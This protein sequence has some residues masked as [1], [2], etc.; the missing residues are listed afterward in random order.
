MC[1]ERHT[2]RKKKFTD[3]RKIV[4]RSPN[5]NSGSFLGAGIT[6][7]FYFIFFCTFFLVFSTFSAVNTYY[8]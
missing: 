4:K 3:T 7:D 6:G 8:F 2:Q 5:V 1:R